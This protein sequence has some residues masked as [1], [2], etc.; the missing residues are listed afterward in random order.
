M[1][2]M[3]FRLPGGSVGV[4]MVDSWFPDPLLLLAAGALWP[5]WLMAVRC[6]GLLT[7]APLF[8]SAVVPHRVRAA[9]AI[10]LGTV[11]SA[12][13]A[14]PASPA[15]LL[16]PEPL[17]LSLGEFALGAALGLGV[18]LVLAGLN[19][20]ASL[21]EQQWGIAAPSTS[22]AEEAAPST[23][24]MRL[25][26]ALGL[27]LFLTSAPLG[28]DLRLVQSWLDSLRMLPP[29]GVGEI[30][31]PARFL[32]DVVALS[33]WLGLQTA[34]PV[35]AVVGLTQTAWA[36]LA[37]NRGGAVWQAPLSPVRFL[38]GVVVLAATLTGM[39]ERIGEVFQSVSS[40]AQGGGVSG[41][42]SPP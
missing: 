16:W 7:V 3:P 8:G 30:E 15:P 21:L 40:A 37:R 42:A 31:A 11:A 35:V 6:Y 9:L 22:T 14:S 13:A 1:I 2:S 41:G 28:G 29:G 26:G 18:R 5:V 17:W 27:A 36:M 32:Q 12:T 38:L 25:L 23:A 19:V 10:V 4:L 33:L 34:A 24:T 20:A 39:C